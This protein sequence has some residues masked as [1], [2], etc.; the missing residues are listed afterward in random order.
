LVYETKTNILV[1][2]LKNIYLY[3][4]DHDLMDKHSEELDQMDL[5][6]KWQYIPTKYPEPEHFL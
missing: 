5:P 6:F 2:Y 4:V 3:A 1:H